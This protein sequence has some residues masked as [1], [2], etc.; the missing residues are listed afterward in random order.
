MSARRLHSIHAVMKYNGWTNWETWS[1]RMHLFDDV[2]EMCVERI[3]EDE[4][5]AERMTQGDVDEA[6][7]ECCD[8]ISNEF[9]DWRGYA[10]H[11]THDW[12][13]EIVNGFQCDVNWWEL[14]AALHDT[15]KTHMKE[16]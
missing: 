10:E 2:V 14:G 12:L 8:I 5:F 9:A 13:T 16:Q 4:A 1:V 7:S 6:T 3:D 15:L 11:D